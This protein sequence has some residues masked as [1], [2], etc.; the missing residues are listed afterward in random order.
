MAI[1]ALRDLDHEVNGSEKDIRS[2]AIDA[3]RLVDEAATRWRGR[4]AR[5]ARP[6]RVRWLCDP[7][8]VEGDPPALAQ[9]LDNLISNAIDHGSGPI[10][11][12]ATMR[13]RA[14]QIAVRDAGSALP[15]LRVPDR[16]PRHGHGL[17]VAGRVAARHGGSFELRRERAGTIASL[18]LPVAE[19]QSPTP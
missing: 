5:A 14:L 7:A 9:A 4:A 17:R 8:I 18:R 6:L 12:V 2:T 1:Y 13:E 3:R 10:T 16:D 11:L 15:R 19:R